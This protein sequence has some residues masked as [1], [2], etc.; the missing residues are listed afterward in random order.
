MRLLKLANAAWR[1][2]RRALTFIS[3]NVTNRCTQRCPMCGVWAAP[4][5]ELSVAEIAG[6]FSELRRAGAAVIEVSGGEPFLRSDI[7]EILEAFDRLGYLYT[8]TTNGTLLTPENVDRLGTCSGLL[9][10]AVSLDSL[11]RTRY[12]QLRGVDSL[13]RVLESLNMIAAARRRLPAK[14]N[15]TMSRVNR[16]EILDILEFAKKRGLGISVFPVAQGAGLAHRAQDAI[17]TATETERREMAGLFRRLAAL[18]R[19]G[20]PLWEYS[21]YYDVAADYVSGRSIGACDAGR[22]FLDVRANGDV[23]ACVDLPAFA[24]LRDGAVSQALA[25]VE[26]DREHIKACAESTPCCYTC[27]ANITETARHPLRFGVETARVWSR[28]RGVRAQ[29]PQRGVAPSAGQREDCS[30]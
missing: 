1:M 10:L 12:A 29:H 9:Q 3:F 5:D 11:D 20:E 14:L 23:A 4:C 17:F 18:R 28:S 16:D 22:V 30:R 6:V 27:T 2:R 8:V 24:S 19:G 21:G 25:R 7:F 15:V 26:G 13:P